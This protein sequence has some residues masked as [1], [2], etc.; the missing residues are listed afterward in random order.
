M[1]DEFLKKYHK[2]IRPMSETHGSERIISTGLLALDVAHGIGG[3]RTGAVMRILGAPGVGKS[4]LT[5]RL[6]ASGQLHGMTGLI[7]DTEAKFNYSVYCQTLESFGIDPDSPRQPILYT[8]QVSAHQAKKPSEM[9]TL[10]TALPMIVDFMQPSVSPNGAVIVLDSVDS[11]ATADQMNKEVHEVT[12]GQ[13]Q[14]IL[15]NFF[16]MYKAT[17]VSTN[18][19]LVFVHQA[20][21]NI[22]PNSYQPVVYGGGYGL[23]HA[24]EFVISMAKIGRISEGTGEEREHLGDR[25]QIKIEKTTQGGRVYGTTVVPLRSDVGFDDA[26]IV[27]DYA[28]QC[29]FIEASGIWLNL[30]GLDG[31]PLKVQGKRNLR[32]ILYEQPELMQ[33][34]TEQVRRKLFNESHSGD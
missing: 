6:I 7:I 15:K 5:Y 29:G 23:A 16:R 31:K 22:N 26:E 28:T 9:L 10:E 18:S 27:I 34:L 13:A 25:I 30:T 14:R 19:L 11:I 2:L 3:V 33:H 24:A 12:V 32:A 21:A 4:S 20:Q 17:V 1:V 8:T